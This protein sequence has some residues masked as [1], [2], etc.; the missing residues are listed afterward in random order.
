MYIY[1]DIY[2][3]IFI[4][5]CTP[6]Q[7]L[8]RKSLLNPSLAWG[9][10]KVSLFSPFQQANPLSDIKIAKVRRVGRQRSANMFLLP[11]ILFFFVG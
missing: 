9:F 1:I 6:S 3:C 8:L 11:M 7:R 4:H 2:V 10:R 5:T